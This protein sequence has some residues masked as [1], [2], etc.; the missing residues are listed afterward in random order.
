LPSVEKK[1]A[2]IVFLATELISLANSLNIDVKT[3]PFW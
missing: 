1:V 2:P 3:I